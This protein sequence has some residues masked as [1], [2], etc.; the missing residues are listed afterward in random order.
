[1]KRPKGL[2]KRGRI[3]WIGI[4]GPDGKPYCESTSTADIRLAEALLIQRKREVQEGKLP[5]IKEYTFQELANEYLKYCENQKSFKNSKVYRVRQL[6]ETF[7]S[8]LLRKFS[9]RIL[10]QYQVERL[11]INKPGGV[12][13][14][15]GVLRNMFTKAVEWEMVSED[16]LRKIRKVKRIKEPPGRLRYLSKEECQTLIEA[17][18]PHLK[19]IV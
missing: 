1:M 5:K 15:M 7:G 9:T 6:V 19:P 2:Y 13:R 4:K 8:L 11:K 10:E 12:N 3:W 14:L 18:A 16:I 17:C